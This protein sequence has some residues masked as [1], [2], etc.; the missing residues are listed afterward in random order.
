ME[1]WSH[2]LEVSRARV[3][4]IQSIPR[5]CIIISAASHYTVTRDTHYISTDISTLDN[6]SLRLTSLSHLP[7]L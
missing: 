4:G 5:A 3:G 6:V 2:F 7:F 1:R